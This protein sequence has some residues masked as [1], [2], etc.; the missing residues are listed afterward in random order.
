MRMKI[1]QKVSMLIEKYNPKIVPLETREI[2]DCEMEERRRRYGD[3]LLATDAIIIRNGKVLLLKD[4]E[5][6]WRLPGGKVE[7]Y[8]SIEEACLRE[9]KEETG[10]NI[11]IVKAVA[12]SIGFRTSPS[13]GKMPA[14]FITFICK[15][16]EDNQR[17]AI[18]AKFMSL[19]EIEKLEKKGCLRFS[20][21]LQFLKS[22]AAQVMDASL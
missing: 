2:P 19:N 15:L 1:P 12:V 4:N 22:Y 5:C 20:Y 7:P 18:N 10:L 11:E 21:I 14:I 8:E 3:V 9:V 17:E 13:A 6:K 16:S